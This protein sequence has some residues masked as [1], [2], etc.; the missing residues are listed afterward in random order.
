MKNETGSKSQ[1]NSGQASKGSQTSGAQ[2][3]K[4]NAAIGNSP[5]KELSTG[6][7]QLVPNASQEL[8]AEQSH[9]NTKKMLAARDA[10]AAFSENVI[11]A[12]KGSLSTTFSKTAWDMMPKDKDGW[13]KEAKTPPEVEN[14]K[15]KDSTDG[16]DTK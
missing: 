2:G 6:Q 15:S 4:S 11:H 1:E 14:L 12:K 16:K 9:E 10:D 8:A 3:E 7:R 13:K 5:Q